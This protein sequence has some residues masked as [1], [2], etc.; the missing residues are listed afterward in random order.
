MNPEL[1]R[2]LWT[3]FSAQRLIVMPLALGAMFALALL[4]GSNNLATLADVTVAVFVVLMFFW[5]TRR[6]ADSIVSE[7]R[8]GTWDAQRMSAQSA[9]TMSWGKL[10]GATAYAWYGAAMCLA[11]Y[12][13]VAFTPETSEWLRWQ[14]RL[15]PDHEGMP[16]RAAM[17]VLVA[18]TGQ[19]A[20]LAC[21]MALVRKRRADRGVSVTLCHFAG[22]IVSVLLFWNVFGW[23]LSAGRVDWFGFDIDA[24]PFTL[25]SAAAFLFWSFLSVLRLMRAELLYRIRP[26]AWAAFAV[27][28]ALW[29]LGLA[30][31]LLVLSGAGV[32]PWLALPF[33]VVAL[34][35]YAAFLLEQKDQVRLRSWLRQIAALRLAR[36][37]RDAPA[38]AQLFA[39]SLVLAA[40]VA[41]ATP[42]DAADAVLAGYVVAHAPA[43]AISAVLF[44][45]RDLALLLSVNLSAN[46]RRGDGSGLVY[47]MLLYVLAPLLARALGD[48]SLVAIF[49]PVVPDERLIS[50]GSPALQAMAMIGLLA[51]QLSRQASTLPGGGRR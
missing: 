22:L 37:A 16:I 43:M 26:W 1:Q 12:L 38:W 42:F 7:L 48:P 47:L 44:L 40:A 10:L 24:G 46:P 5:G 50:V 25:A 35:V 19:A 21:A 32:V 36:A 39:M 27:F 9:F 2:H 30:H 28:I 45:L 41:I 11:A 6:A 33:V 20:A 13:F 4:T 23:F 18:L 34:L 31:H 3:E 8:D 51:W 29:G 49:L 17:M 14:S 15:L